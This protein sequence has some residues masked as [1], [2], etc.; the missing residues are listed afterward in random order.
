M[1][2]RTSDDVS[3]C[4]WHQELTDGASTRI[5]NADKRCEAVGCL[6]D[7]EC[8]AT[9]NGVRLFCADKP[10]EAGTPGVTPAITD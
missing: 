3:N 7:N 8:A 2:R 5:C 6:S 9:I 1:S 10:M 4:A